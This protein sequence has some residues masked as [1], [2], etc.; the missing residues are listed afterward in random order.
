MVEFRSIGALEGI[1]RL[2]AVAHRE[3]RAA[4]P[5]ARAGEKLLAQRMG[6]APLPR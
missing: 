2:L 6:D 4:V 1:D 5:L 3:Y